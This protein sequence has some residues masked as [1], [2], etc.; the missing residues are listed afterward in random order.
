MVAEVEAV[1][2]SV[3]EER[4]RLAERCAALDRDKRAA[5]KAARE[6]MERL[7]EQV[8]NAFLY[9]SVLLQFHSESGRSGAAML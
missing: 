6:E 2:Q 4:K 3:D 7:T 9:S 1:R 8:L 5:N